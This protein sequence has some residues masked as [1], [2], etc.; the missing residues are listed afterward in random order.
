MPY[1][2]GTPE[3]V[4]WAK[5]GEENYR[6]VAVEDTLEELLFSYGYDTPQTMKKVLTDMLN[7]VDQ[8]FEEREMEE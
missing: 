4:K 5:Q 3:Y 6:D 2:F 7:K 1:T 8:F